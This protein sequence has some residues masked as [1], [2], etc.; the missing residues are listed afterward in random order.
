MTPPSSVPI[1]DIRNLNLEF[2]TPRGR[3][4][5]IRDVSIRIPE[6]K[7]V[8]I[9]G[10]SGSGKSTVVSAAM[11]LLANNALIPSGEVLFEGEDILKAGPKRLQE[12]RGQKIS[13][14][15][16]DP[17]T[18]QNPVISIGQQMTDVL[19]RRRDLSYASKRDK[20][21]SMLRKVGISDPEIR[22]EQYPHEFSGGM[23]Q[24]VS[25]AMALLVNPRLL[26]ADEPTTALDVTME[27]QIVHLIR[28]MKAEFEGSVV[29]VSHNLGLI[30]ELCDEVVVMFAGEVVERGT[31]HDIFERAKHPYTR[32]LLECDPALLNRRTR[33]LP[34]IPGSVPDLRTRPDGC[35]FAER[36]P[37]ARPDCRI[38]HPK[39][40]HTGEDHFARCLLLENGGDYTFAD[41]LSPEAGG[42]E[43]PERPQ[44]NSL[45]VEDLRVRFRTEGPISALVKGNRDPFI[46]AVHGVSLEISEGETYGLVGESGSGKTS[47]G[48]AI[49]GLTDAQHGRV[50]F[51]G[52]NLTGLTEKELK[53]VRRD[54][55][56][57]FQDPIASL[58]PRRTTKALV[59]EP[60]DIHGIDDI[61]RDARAKELFD[62][63]GL[64][65]AIL[66]RYP[67]E[68]SGG[69]ARRVGVAR[70]LAL[71]PRLIIADEPTAGL[72]V[73]VQGEIL[74]LMGRLQKEL[75]LSYLVISHNL[76][77]MRHISDK[78]GIMYLGR[79]VE[80]GPASE[81]FAA[82]KHPY[83]QGLLNAIPKPDPN[84]RRAFA[85]IEGEVPSLSDRPT[86]CEF[87][88]RCPFATD[89]CRSE[90]PAVREI[91]P[92]RHIRCHH[93]LS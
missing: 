47:L 72:D 40:I 83:T 36:C 76:P 32:K 37:V 70:A 43:P 48:R 35:V 88:N 14:V 16:Q 27:A 82:P 10:E 42:E 92:G 53:P 90:L 19:Y 41:V 75:G 45:K 4:S 21:I 60:Y 22:F 23:R 66:S 73:S 80:Q 56:M 52:L 59:L 49:I 2:S 74:N 89:I 58:S 7:I 9:V 63:V 34:T 51:G 85:S 79:I 8:G 24:R 28:K 84:A 13:M 68:L 30:A 65:S 1:L 46:D 77:V 12:L 38:H 67:H 26:I 39:E 62:M 18:S 20:V 33:Q 71:S 3:I 61:D 29:F 64:Q 11:R 86:G 54:V 50:E 87:H 15:F 31:V 55:A 57:M 25:I 91:T 6:N 81:I 93:P 5:A 44:K 78:L 69:Q 17:M